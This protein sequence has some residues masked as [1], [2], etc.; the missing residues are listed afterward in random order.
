MVGFRSSSSTEKTT[1]NGRNSLDVLTAKNDNN[2]QVAEISSQY[3]A[4]QTVLKMHF[5]A[6]TLNVVTSVSVRLCSG[7]LYDC[8]GGDAVADRCYRLFL[9]SKGFCC[10]D[11]V[12]IRDY[13]VAW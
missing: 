7:D 4:F 12:P 11:F 8:I 9:Q 10:F 3:Y 6:G 1:C 5:S 13:F 2:N